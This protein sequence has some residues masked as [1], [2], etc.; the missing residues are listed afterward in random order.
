MAPVNEHALEALVELRH[1]PRLVEL[2]IQLGVMLGLIGKNVTLE[3]DPIGQGAD[4]LPTPAEDGDEALVLRI[5]GDAQVLE[6]L[7]GGVVS[8]PSPVPLL[9]VLNLPLHQEEVIVL[10]LLKSAD[11]VYTFIS[12]ETGIPSDSSIP[13][14]IAAT[15]AI[16][17][18]TM[19]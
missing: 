3:L 16:H 15:R 10:P 1:E 7:L 17:A 12:L 11:H 5:D 8:P 4:S 6:L 13:S 19:A 2:V 9:L 14:L 18:M